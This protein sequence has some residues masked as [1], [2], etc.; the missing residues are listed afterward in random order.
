MAGVTTA[1]F[2]LIASMLGVMV[3]FFRVIL[4]VFQSSLAVLALGVRD[5]FGVVKGLV[6]FLLGGCY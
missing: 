4:A 3:N 2:D 5:V 1:V 6:D